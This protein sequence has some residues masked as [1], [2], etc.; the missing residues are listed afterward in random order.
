MR[1][2]IFI[3]LIMFS[4]TILSFA[5]GGLSKPKSDMTFEEYNKHIMYDS[6]EKFESREQIYRVFHLFLQV[7]AVIFSALIPILLNSM[8]DE[9]K[10][11]RL[12]TLLSIFII[13]AIGCSSV[14]KFKEQSTIYGTASIKLR[15]NLM[16]YDTD[17]G[18]YSNIKN[19]TLKLNTYKYLA[20]EIIYNARKGLIETLP[21]S[22]EKPNYQL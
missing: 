20:E 17:R 12:I 7:I 5:S 3:L 21:D 15:K 9:I 8:F 13:I 1:N 11:K 18:F 2:L 4:I 19:D 22:T 16:E 10:S 6:M 14:F